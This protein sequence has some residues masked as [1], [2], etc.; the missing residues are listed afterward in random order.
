MTSMSDAAGVESDLKVRLHALGAIAL[1]IV[2]VSIGVWL[3]LSHVDAHGTR[4]TQRAGAL[5][6]ICGT[7]LAFRSAYVLITFKFKVLR[8]N[9]EASVWYG[10]VAFILIAGGTLLWAFG[11]LLPPL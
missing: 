7:Y 1:A 6:I 9:P 10:V 2:F 11:D 3:E 4:W 5:V 8:A